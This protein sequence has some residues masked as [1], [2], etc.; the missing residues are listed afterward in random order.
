MEEYRPPVVR[1]LIPIE[2][3]PK[4]KGKERAEGNFCFS[5]RVLETKGEI[6]DGSSGD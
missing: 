1:T 6:V 2:D 5:F 3:S 4:G